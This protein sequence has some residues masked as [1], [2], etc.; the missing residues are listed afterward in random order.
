MTCF[1]RGHKSRA[2]DIEP[3]ACL[4]AP[5]GEDGKA[6]VAL[7]AGGG[8]DA[9][10]D[11]AL[12]HQ[13]EPVVPRRPWLERQP[14]DQQC[15]GNIVRQIR[16][17]P[18]RRRTEERARIE[19]EG[20]AGNDLEP[21]GV[22][23]GDLL[24]RGNR[25]LVALDCDHASRA[26][27]EQGTREP[28]GAGADFDHLHAFERTRGARDA[29]GEVQ[30]KKEMLSERLFGAKTMPPD[31]LAERRKVIDGAHARR[32]TG[33]DWARDDSLAASC[34]AAIRLVGSARPVPAMSKAVPWSGE[35]RTNG[36]PRVTLTA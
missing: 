9:F 19:V 36:K 29:R 2:R 12:E 7:G 16:N 3:N 30:I 31:H 24:Q 10:G 14:A 28:T 22:A 27:H 25:A 32:A 15:G 5:A 33:A 21:P 4:A 11:F 1:G 20:V 35:V 26:G 18:R 13:R 17:D 23:C 34:R 6:S 8:H